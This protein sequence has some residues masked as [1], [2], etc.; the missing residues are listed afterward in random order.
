MRSIKKTTKTPTDSFYRIVKSNQRLGEIIKFQKEAKKHFGAL[1]S[2]Q[3]YSAAF[4]RTWSDRIMDSDW[5]NEATDVILQQLFTN[6]TKDYI[7]EHH[8]DAMT[9]GELLTKEKVLNVG[10][11]VYNIKQL[12]IATLLA[13]TISD[14]FSAYYSLWGAKELSPS[15]ELLEEFTCLPLDYDFKELPFL[16]WVNLEG[17][18][19]KSSGHAFR[20]KNYTEVQIGKEDIVGVLI[21]NFNEIYKRTEV[22]E[23]DIS[24]W[25]KIS[26]CMDYSMTEET[27]LKI[28]AYK[29]HI[30]FALFTTDSE[31]SSITQNGMFISSFDEVQQK[32]ELISE[33]L[34]E[35]LDAFFMPGCGRKIGLKEHL[36]WGVDFSDYG[37]A[38]DL[39]LKTIKY[40]QDSEKISLK[41]NYPRPN[42]KTSVQKTKKNRKK[43]KQKSTI[44]Y[45]QIEYLKKP[46]VDDLPQWFKKDQKP[47]TP[48]SKSIDPRFMSSHYRRIWVTDSYI[49]KKGIPEEQVLAVE[50]NRPRMNKI[51]KIIY[52]KRNLVA[53][54]ID[55]GHEP[56]AKVTRLS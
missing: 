4:E 3:N 22:L 39:A 18:G 13:N 41:E 54:K 12:S 38:F 50:D 31:G 32:I 15:N 9:F 40:S 36:S 46:K 16:T 5:A 10:D 25:D 30:G 27:D 55:T 56:L 33:G 17:F 7:L 49:E 53:I 48:R 8:I 6:Y 29:D 37:L 47:S 43:K 51:G 44:Q 52:K 1:V 42:S 21:L 28:E 20:H 35:S 2:K 26:Y 23:G 34:G 45:F 14:P 24:V 19:L 11:K